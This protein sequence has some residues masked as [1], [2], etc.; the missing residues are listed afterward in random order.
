[1]ADLERQGESQS[2]ARAW[3]K[4]YVAALEEVLD[5]EGISL[6]RHPRRATAIPAEIARTPLEK[7]APEQRGEGTIMDLSLGGC[8][9]YTT[10]M[11]L[12][13]GEII[14]LTFRL[15]G[16]STFVMLH[17]HV[18]RVNKVNGALGAGVEFTKLPEDIVADLQAFL[19][20][21]PSAEE[22]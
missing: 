20:L 12:T 5:L 4:G 10:A 16:S 6:R 8:R 18:R 17:G 21:P 19:T 22:L 2:A 11:E 14:E 1:L 15:P 7:G 9:L 3:Q 13:E